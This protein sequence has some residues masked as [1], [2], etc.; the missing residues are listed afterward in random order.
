MASKIW[1]ADA[2][3]VAQ[4]VTITITAY[5]AA[6]TYKA[7]VNGKTVSVLGTTDA[8]TTASALFNALTASTIPEFAEA[9]WAWTSG[10]SLTGTMNTP[11]QPLILTTSVTGGTGTISSSTTTANNSNNSWGTAG[12]WVPSGVPATG[13]DA[14]LSNSSTSA[15]YDL[16]QS[17]VTLASLSLP[18]SYTGFVGLPENNGSYYEYRDTY[19]AIGSTLTTIG[20]GPGSGSGRIKIDNGTVQTALSILNTASA[21]DPSRQAVLWK[22]THAAN[23]VAI[24]KGSLGVATL[25]GE[26]ATILT[27]LIGYVSNKEGDAT[28]YLGTGCTLTTITKS[29]GALTL[30]SDVTTLTQDAGTTDHLAGTITT[31]NLNGGT[32]Y[33]Q[34]VGT[35]TNLVVLEGA[36]LDC[37]R[38]QRQRTVTN[39]T[40]FKGAEVFDPSGTLIF[41]NDYVIP[42]GTAADCKLNFGTNRTYQVA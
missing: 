25:P 8:A 6:T 28:V 7:T 31:L 20:A 42:N 30:Q 33:Y 40:F 39:A 38:D 4:V 13:D 26:L 29:G 22:G 3:N 27:L 2:P 24:N 37:S 21:A 11:G 36:V 41:T 16:A 19:L 5:D 12:N 35:I 14:D 15:L 23:A 17:A 32:H 9:V 10:A 34:S 1:R 18:S